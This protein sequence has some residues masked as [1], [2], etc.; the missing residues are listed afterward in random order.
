GGGEGGA[1]GVRGEARRGGIDVVRRRAL[2]FGCGAGRLTQALAAY[3]ERV[4]GVDIAASMLATARR[5]N[6]H[7]ETCHY[8][9][10]TA[11]DLRLFESGAFTFA[12]SVLV[13]QHIEPQHSKAYLRELLRLLA[14]GGLL[15]FQL[16][17]HRSA[18]EPPAA[19]PRTAVSAPLP[20]S[21]RRAP[22]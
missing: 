3:F 9:L 12:Y 21:A 10:N 16:P 15:V 1:A 13:L 7:P 22:I 2:D 5:Y 14:P 6:R 20:P 17:S 18:D 8:H 11:P 4:D 19:A